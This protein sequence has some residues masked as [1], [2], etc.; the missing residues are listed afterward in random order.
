MNKLNVFIRWLKRNKTGAIL[1]GIWA[2]VSYFWWALRC[3][4][5]CYGPQYYKF[6]SNILRKSQ[7]FLYQNYSS[8]FHQILYDQAVLFS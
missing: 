5:G 8:Y 7:L 6:S 1:G 4:G 2:I 3:I